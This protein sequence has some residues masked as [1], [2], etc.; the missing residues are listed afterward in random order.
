MVPIIYSRL[1]TQAGP[2]S[3]GKLPAVALTKLGAGT[4]YLTNTV[5]TASNYSG[6]TVIAGGI[7]N[8]QT[9][10]PSATTTVVVGSGAT[11][12]LQAN[13]TVAN[14]SAAPGFTFARPLFLYGSGV[15]GNG[16]LESVYGINSLTSTV[17]LNAP[18]AIGVDAGTLTQSGVIS[19]QGSLIKVGG[20]TLAAHRG[21]HLRG[22]RF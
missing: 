16:A 4:L 22:G 8:V 5:G 1:P 15:N 20:G 13:L 11:L 14:G 21:Q 10:L 2:P 17:A 3:L 18:A 19:G 9:G 12:Q 6:L 7:L